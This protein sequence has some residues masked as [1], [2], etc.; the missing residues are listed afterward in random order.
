MKK[1]A[2]AIGGKLMSSKKHGSNNNYGGHPGYGHTS[3]NP[4]DING[5]FKSSVNIWQTL[6]KLFQ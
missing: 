5:N 4:L 2:L 1:D 3:R 6:Y